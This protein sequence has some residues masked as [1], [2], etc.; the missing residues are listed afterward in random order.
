MLGARR[1]HD[2]A[3]GRCSADRGEGTDGGGG[4]EMVVRSVWH[5]RPCVT[6]GYRSF[7]AVR[8]HHFKPYEC[9]SVVII[10]SLSFNGGLCSPSS[11]FIHDFSAGQFRLSVCPRL[12]SVVYY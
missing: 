1:E 5:Q 7:T 3:D 11:A 2:A 8:H 4:G 10:G 6:T 9:L 12:S